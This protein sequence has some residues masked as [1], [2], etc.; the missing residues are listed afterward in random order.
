MVHRDGSPLVTATL[1]TNT[2][3]RAPDNDAESPGPFQRGSY[4]QLLR[5]PVLRPDLEGA[6][7]RG[8][9]VPGVAGPANGVVDAIVVPTIR[10]AEQLRSA[11]KL[12][13]DARCQ[14]VTLH[15]HKFPSGLTSVLGKLGR[16]MATPLALRSSAAHYLLDLAAGLPQAVRSPSAYDISRKRNLGLLIGRAC[17]WNRMLFLDDDIRRLDVDKLSAASAGLSDYPVVGLQVGKHPDLSVIGHARRL[18]G[19]DQKPF[20]SGGSLLVNPQRLNGFFPAVYHEDWLSIINHLRLGEVAVSGQ[21][22]QLAYNPFN[23]SE[24]AC[25]E[26]F[27][28][29]LAFGLLWL[30]ESKKNVAAKDMQPVGGEGSAVAQGD[31]W[32]E[33]THTTF[34]RE[35][36]RQR[37][38]LLEDLAM[39]LQLRSKQEMSPLKSVRAAQLQCSSLSPEE[40]SSFIRKWI[41]NLSIWQDR[42]SCLPK[43]DSVIKALEKLGMRHVV[44]MHE[45]N[46]RRV[47]AALAIGTNSAR[48]MSTKARRPGFALSLDGLDESSP[49]GLRRPVKK[50]RQRVG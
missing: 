19:D 32:N 15:S 45:R 43:S 14:L 4:P 1:E 28:D 41:E 6:R 24:R 42:T 33:A 36:L 16:G 25:F 46:P 48:Q 26:E 44:R 2:Q 12:A 37:A 34:W 35:I 8:A 17:G 3:F 13:I 30:I 10:S 23:N 38:I 18:T 49:G 11:V 27:G 21:V 9:G 39:R 20:I 40:F 7:M 50:L 47:R 22:T 5:F 29:I 31:Y